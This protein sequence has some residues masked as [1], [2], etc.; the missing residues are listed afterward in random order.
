[1]FL[2]PRYEF[3]IVL[4]LIHFVENAVFL[5]AQTHTTETIL[6]L[7]AV[8]TIFQIER[9]HFFERVGAHAISQELG[10]IN[11]SPARTF[12][13]E[14]GST[15][16][17]LVITVF[18]PAGDEEIFGVLDFFPLENITGIFRFAYVIAG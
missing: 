15:V 16:R 14:F 3:L 7:N 9:V 4:L 5:I 1:L 8:K 2:Y 18:H 10:I 12:V 13:A 11:P 17:G 6:A